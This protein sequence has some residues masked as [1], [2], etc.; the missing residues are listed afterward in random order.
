[1][2]KYAR[3]RQ[4]TFDDLHQLTVSLRQWYFEKGGLFLS[5]NSRDAYFALQDEIREVLA[6]DNSP[7]SEVD[8]STYEALR[9]KGSSLRTALTRDVGT[10]K[11]PR[12]N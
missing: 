6:R 8:E 9:K 4:L 12:L 2:A 5:D 10:R 7:Q 11:A 3:P 1:M